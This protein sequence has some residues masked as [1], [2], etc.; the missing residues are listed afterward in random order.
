MVMNQEVDNTLNKTL[1]IEKL[2]YAT[3]ALNHKKGSPGK[4]D[5]G[6]QLSSDLRIT[7]PNISFSK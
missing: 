3:K 1:R 7:Y 5:Q 4:V 2:K 6:Q